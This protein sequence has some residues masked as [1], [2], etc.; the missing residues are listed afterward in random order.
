MDNSSTTTSFFQGLDSEF[1]L[2][3]ASAALTL[4]NI[5]RKKK[6]DN[7]DNISSLLNALKTSDNSDGGNE[8]S[9]FFD[10]VSEYV[11]Q[12][13]YHKT[14]SPNEKPDRLQERF[15]EF[16]V[17]L[18]KI[19]SQPSSIDDENQLERLRDFCINLSQQSSN[20]H[21]EQEDLPYFYQLGK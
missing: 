8:V 10:P 1:P 13:A 15:D 7:T 4:D 12:S 18:E 5:R 20:F 6:L 3:A 9:A 21:D 17:S 16:I 2:L 11:F 14:Y 19:I